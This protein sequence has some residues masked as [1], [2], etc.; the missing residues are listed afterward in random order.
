M[1]GTLAILRIGGRAAVGPSSSLPVCTTCIDL[2]VK[3]THARLAQSVER[4]ALNLVVVGSSPTLGV[5][6]LRLFTRSSPP[7]LLV[8]YMPH[9]ACVQSTTHAIIRSFPRTHPLRAG[10]GCKQTRTPT[11]YHGWK[12][13]RH[14]YSHTCT[15]GIH[16][17]MG[18][19]L[20]SIQHCLAVCCSR[21]RKGVGHTPGST[22]LSVS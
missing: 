13:K 16:A 3:W 8:Q 4:K 21:G 10:L 22:A 19:D 9:Y 6:F 15:Y 2:F 18:G 7:H 17:C 5:R 12:A 14:A 11:F 1:V 20:L